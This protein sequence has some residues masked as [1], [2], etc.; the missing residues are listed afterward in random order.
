M[1]ENIILYFF[2]QFPL[3]IC[4]LILCSRFLRSRYKIVQLYSLS[5]F[6]G[7][8]IKD[9]AL[10]ISKHFFSA[11]SLTKQKEEIFSLI[12]H[13]NLQ[14]NNKTTR[15]YHIYSYYILVMSLTSYLQHIVNIIIILYVQISSQILCICTLYHYIFYHIVLELSLVVVIKYGKKNQIIVIQYISYHILFHQFCIINIVYEL[16]II[17]LPY[18]L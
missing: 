3:I 16:C 7:I 13:S 11:L 8:T 17:L 12:Q 1:N 6:K 5:S 18:N 4:L 15:K 10:E 9:L 14:Q 2:C